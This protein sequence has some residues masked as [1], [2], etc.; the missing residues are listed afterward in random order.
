[1]RPFPT[2][3]QDG[4]SSG[5]C[6]S[7]RSSLWRERLPARSAGRRL[8][9]VP[10]V[11]RRG[12][13][14]PEEGRA[15]PPP[16]ERRRP[17]SGGISTGER[18]PCPGSHDLLH[19]AQPA[20]YSFT[21]VRRKLLLYSTKGCPAAVT[22]LLLLLLLSQVSVSDSARPRRRQPTRLLSLGSSRQEHWRGC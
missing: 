2:R 6:R 22:L 17:R 10:A 19:L 21:T 5:L 15:R 14:Q 8:S 18:V 12:Q 20:F 16:Q 3:R 1:M 9:S 7:P 11:P 4:G 13:Q